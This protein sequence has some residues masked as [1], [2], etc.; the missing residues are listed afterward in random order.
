MKPSL[1]TRARQYLL[2]FNGVNDKIVNLHL[3]S[4]KTARKKNLHEIYLSMINHA[5]NRQSMPNTIGDNEKLR[6]AL[7]NFDPTKIIKKYEDH[8]DLLQEIKNKKIKTPSKID[9][10]N[11]RS[12]WVIYAKSIISSAKFI[13]SFKKAEDFH[14]FVESFYVNEHSRLA[15]PLLLKEEIS[16]YG[17]ALACDFLKENGYSGFIKPDT[18]INDI[19]RA[20]GITSAQTDYGVFKDTIAYCTKNGLVPY[21]FDKLIWLVGSGN[22]Y[23]SDLTVKTNKR[24]FITENFPQ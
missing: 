17:F 10:S 11:N 5:K 23:L 18:H 24:Q 20:A 16:G 3:H 15:L 14:N 9:M 22:F 1:E 19:C 21:E 8:N 6:D 12:H 13:S 2:S 7:F 4:W